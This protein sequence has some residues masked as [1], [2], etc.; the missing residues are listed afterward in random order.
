[1][2]KKEQL[3]KEEKDFVARTRVQL[4]A[5]GLKGAELNKELRKRKRE[6]LDLI[7]L[8]EE[9]EDLQNN[10]LGYKILDNFDGHD[11][12]NIN[13]FIEWA[14]ENLPSF[15]QIADIEALGARL[16]N[17][18]MT[19]GAFAIELSKI[20]G[21][22]DLVGKIYVGENNPFKY[23]EAF[24]A[25]FRMLLSEAEITKYLRIARREKLA[26]L[27]KEGK[28]LRQALDELQMQSPLYQKMSQQELEDTLF[29]EYLA[30]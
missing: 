12:E 4:E 22:L 10:K 14:K 30:E 20:A 27:K 24:H 6:D 28:T 19:A 16:K 15:I 29:E 17:N 18:G 3:K 7:K 23:H 25:V 8:R 11:V 2:P 1:M 21:G 5:D 13:R 26:E 9:I